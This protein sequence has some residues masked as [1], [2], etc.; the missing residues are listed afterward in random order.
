MTKPKAKQA[1]KGIVQE[2]ISDVGDATSTAIVV[3]RISSLPWAL[4]QVI[5]LEKKIFNKADSWAGNSSICLHR[6]IHTDIG[7]HLTTVIERCAHVQ[8]FCPKR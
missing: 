5:T 8:A 4:D 1:F 6:P 3:D 2:A 7:Q